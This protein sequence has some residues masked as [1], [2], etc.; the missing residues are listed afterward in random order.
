MEFTPLAFFFK[1]F[2][3]F[4]KFQVLPRRQENLF[5]GE[6]TEL[7]KKNEEKNIVIFT[8]SLLYDHVLPGAHIQLREDASQIVLRY[9]NNS[10]LM[11]KPA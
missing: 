11:H 5:S 3:Y 6:K 10:A 7:K 8:L 4:R 9:N 1:L 2:K